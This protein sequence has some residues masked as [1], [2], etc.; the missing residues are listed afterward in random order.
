MTIEDELAALGTATV[1]EAS[2]VDCFL[3][4]TLRPVWPEAHVVGTALPVSMA[5][6]DNL[7]LHV[8]LEHAAPGDVL[9]ADGQG[10][11]HGYWGEILASAAQR[12]GVLGLVIDGGVRDTVR[13]RELDFPVFSSSVSMRGT[14]K[15]DAGTVGTPIHLGGVTVRRG[16]LV[17]ADADGV[18]VLPAELVEQTTKAARER[19]AKET[20]YLRRIADGELTMDIY[21]FRGGA[22]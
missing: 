17:V 9:V 11:A 4:A 19:Q 3:P 10:A 1:Y 6:G 7:P 2:G 8:A 16:D 20:E 5:A 18:L 13:L 22:G 15:G 14:R 21:G 12:R